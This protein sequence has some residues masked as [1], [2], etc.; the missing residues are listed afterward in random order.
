MCCVSS[1]CLACRPYNDPLTTRQ[2]AQVARDV[3]DG[4]DYLH[5]QG[6]LHVDIKP[7][8]VLL[9]APMRRGHDAPRA[10]LADLGLSCRLEEGKSFALVDTIR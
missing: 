6:I 1:N 5:S 2:I 10:V 9:E 3:A 8:N 4:M 7:S